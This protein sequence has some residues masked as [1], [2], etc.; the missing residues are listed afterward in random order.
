MQSYIIERMNVREFERYYKKL[1]MPLCMYALRLVEESTVSED[2]VQDAFIKAWRYSEEGGVI[3]SFPSF[4]YRTVRNECL[5]F[6]RGKKTMVGEEYIPEVSETDI[7]TSER[8]AKIWRAIGMLP[9]KCKKVFL[10]S[11]QKGM[12][13]EQI[14]EEMGIAVKTVKNQ[15]T[16]ALSRLREVLKD[17]E[18]PFF[19]PFL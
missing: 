5:L 4:M 18:K 7:D 11:K 19:L 3:S 2:V 6:L 12:S 15:M 9:E 1:Y 8:D 14:A 10:M 16:K 13:N 17:G